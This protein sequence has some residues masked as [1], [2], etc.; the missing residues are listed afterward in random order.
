MHKTLLTIVGAGLLALPAI[1]QDAKLLAKANSMADKTEKK[2]IEWRRDFHEHPE[3]GNREVKTAEK[4]AAELKR[5]GIE[6]ETS[7]AHTG[8]V[9]VLKGGKPG[10]VVALRADMDGLPVTERANL[11]YAS[12]AKSTYN[13][14]EVGVM[15]AC[16]HDTHVAML[17]GAAEVLAGMKK[18]LPGTVKFIFQPA[19]EGAPAGEKGGASLM[20]EEGVLS[21][22]PKPEVIFGLHINSQ[23]EVGKLKYRPGGIMASADLLKIK[24]K[25]KQV[26]GASPWAGVDPIVASAQI[27]N[28]LQTIVSRQLDLTEDAAVVT[29]GSIHGG[30]RNNI[31]PEEVLL[32]GTIRSLNPEMQKQIHEKIKLTATKIAESTGA[33]AEVTIA[34]MAPVTFNDAGLTQKMLPTLQTI[35]GKDN[36]LLM[37]AMTGAEDFAYYQQKIPGLFVFVGGMKKGQDPATAPAHH[38]PDFYIDE[39]GM[40]LGVKTLL[41][42]TLNYMTGK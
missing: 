40:K 10:P 29:I 42:L 16:G 3:L 9:G 26:H 13:G 21:K 28:G 18:D 14:Q 34:E 24:V 12:K 17:L 31:I 1:A 19:E 36:V 15:H 39:S 6:V 22:G 20:V 11:P 38:T 8:V 2:V 32:E 23:T 4:I 37:N 5:F 35:A 7:V 33:T 27:I 25:G 30:V 41:G